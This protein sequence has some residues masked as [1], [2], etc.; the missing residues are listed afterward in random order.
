MA[1]SSREAEY[2]AQV[3]AVA[4]RIGL[5]SIFRDLGLEAS[6]EVRVDS[7]TAKPTASRIGVGKVKYI[8]TKLLWIQEAVRDGKVKLTKIPGCRK[9]ADVLSKPMSV[10]WN[11]LRTS[12]RGD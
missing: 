11:E 4:E 8:H 1:L 3:K 9:R 7:P 6:V 2:S 5:Q 12:L 10:S